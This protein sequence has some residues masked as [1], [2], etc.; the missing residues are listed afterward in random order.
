MIYPSKTV[1]V[2]HILFMTRIVL[3][4]K[5]VVEWSSVELAFIP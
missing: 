3:V 5:P 4:Y 1:D 2:D